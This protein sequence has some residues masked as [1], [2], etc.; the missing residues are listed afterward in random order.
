SEN[1]SCH[2]MTSARNALSWS[3]RYGHVPYSASQNL[4]TLW[5]SFFVLSASRR[6]CLVLSNSRIRPDSVPTSRCFL[7]C[8]AAAKLVQHSAEPNVPVR[9]VPVARW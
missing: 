4:K 5:Y 3:A 7:D 1:L 6:H 2:L 8:S 9:R